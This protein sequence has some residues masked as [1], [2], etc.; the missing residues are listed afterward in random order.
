[1]TYVVCSGP[2][3]RATYEVNVLHHS[4]IRGRDSITNISITNKNMAFLGNKLFLSIGS[5]EVQVYTLPRK[6]DFVDGES[7]KYK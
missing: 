3:I 5:M 6:P 4:I 1:M 7:V 2:L